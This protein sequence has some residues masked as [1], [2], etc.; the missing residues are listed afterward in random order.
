MVRLSLVNLYLHGFVQPQVNEYDTLTSEDRWNDYADV[1]LANPPFMSPKGGIKPHKRFS[2]QSNR[3]E[4]LFVDYMAEHLTPNGRAAIIVPEG[5]IFQSAGAYKQLRKYLVEQNYLWAVVS[6]PAGVFNPYAGV[7]TS[8]LF[9]DRTLAKKTD[10][11]LF[12]KIEADGFDLGAQRRQADKN[13]LPNALNVLADW[14]RIVRNGKL[15]DFEPQKQPCDALLVNINRL[16]ESEEYNLSGE[17][18]REV[19]SR[20]HHKWEKISLN[21]LCEIVRGSSPRP[22]GNPKYFGGNV[23]R[24]MVADVTRDGMYVT[25]KID[26]LTE[27]GAKQSR[28]MKKGDLVMAVSGQPGLCAILNVDACIHDGFAGF[29]N[30]DKSKISTEFL[31]HYLTSQRKANNSQSVGAIFLN[32]NTDQLRKI[33]IPLLPLEIQSQIVDEIEGCQRIIDGA[34]Q[35]VDSWKPNLELEIEEE[36]KSV[37]VEAWEETKLG[38]ALNFVGSGVTPLGGKETYLSEGILFIRS[39][40]VL[41]GECDFSDVAYISQEVHDEMTRSKVQKYDVLLNITGAS[42]GRS[43]VYAEDKEANVNQHVTIL[44]CKEN[45]A[46]SFLMYYLISKPGQYQIGSMQ[47]GASRQALNYQQI[48]NFKIPLPPLDVQCAIIKRI[49]AERD[50]VES[51]RRLIEIYESKIKKVIERVW[52]G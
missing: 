19:I 42:I 8:I 36:R 9:L 17:R 28:P 44:R 23:P 31:Y 16:A 18:Y 50:M 49:E 27:E 2:V 22:Q 40:N 26:T 38:N 43:A 3:S 24:L 13:D 35:V 46:P 48:R 4:V 37:G 14:Q 41:W 45:L 39:Q 15:D 47:S 29:R 5:I 10:Q 11:I 20:K 52:E 32:L 7:K 12:V 33:E 21:D 1:I 25:P 6:L 34:R 51:N 30:L